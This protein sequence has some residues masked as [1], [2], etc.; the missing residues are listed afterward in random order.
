M[1]NLTTRKIVLGM[2]MVLMLAFSVQGTADAINAL[3]PTFSPTD[4]NIVEIN[5]TITLT[6]IS[7]TETLETVRESVT[8]SVRGSG[9][10]TGATQTNFLNPDGN[11]D[12][13][14]TWSE[15]GVNSD[16]SVGP[17][18][19]SVTIT[20][21]SA[22]EVTVTVTY[23]ETYDTN[24]SRNTSIVGTFYVPKQAYQVG[25]ND[26]VRLLGVTKGVGAGY[27]A[28][29]NFRIHTGDGRNN[30]VTYAIA[31]G[32]TLYIREGNRYRN[33][34]AYIKSNETNG[35]LTTSS[36]ADVWLEMASASQT[37]T[38]TVVTT[39]NETEGVYILRVPKLSVTA[40]TLEDDGT[41][42][43]A[44]DPPNNPMTAQPV[45]LMGD[46]E[47]VI[48]ADAI[49]VKVKQ[50]SVVNNQ[51]VFTTDVANVPVKFDVVDKSVTGGYLI[52]DA[53]ATIVDANNNLIA[54]ADRPRAARTLYVRTDD[55]NIAPVGFQFGTAE[56]TSEI[57]VSVT[58]NRINISKTIDVVIGD[59][60]SSQ[61]S[62]SSNTRDS[63]NSNVF[64]LVA[65]VADK[66]GNPLWGVPV[67]FR[68]RFG[69]LENTPTGET[70]TLPDDSPIA[71]TTAE[72]GRRVTDYTTRSGLAR[73]IYDL[74]SNTGSQEIHASI[75]DTASNR[76][77]VTF[78]VNG[79]ADTST[80][81]G[82]DTG[83]TANTITISPAT[84][85]G[86]PG[87]TV[88]ITISNPAGAP[89][90]LSSPSTTDFPQT[91]FAPASGIATSFTSTVTLPDR[92]DTY[93]I[94]AATTT[95][96]VTAG[97]AT[98]T[99]ATAAK[100][101]LA[102]SGETSG[103]PGAQITVA[104]IATDATGAREVG[105]DF[106]ISA[107]SI[108]TARGTTGANGVGR[109]IVT[110]PSTVSTYSLTAK[111]DGYTDRP[112]S[113]TVSTTGQ[114]TQ[115]QPTPPPTPPS[116]VSEPSRIV[117]NGPA[118]RSGTVNEALEAPLLAQ[119]LDADDDG[120]ENAIVKFSVKQGRARLSQRGDGKA[121]N[122]RTDSQGYARANLTPL[123]AG[124]ITIDA[125][126]RG[127]R[128]TVSFTITT[129][130]APASG[131]PDA[132]D[133]TPSTTVS[134]VLNAGVSA[135]S[136]PPM[137]WV[138]GGKIYALVDSEVKVFISNVENATNLTVGGG[139]V[140]WTAK[141][142]ETHGTLNSANLDGTDA[143]Q[144]RTVWGV[145]RGITLDPTGS[146]LYWVDA[147]GRLQRSELDGS[148]IENVIRNLSDPKD[149]AISDRNAYW[150]GNGSGTDTLSFISLSDPKKEINPIAATSGVYGGLAITNGKLYWTE[151]TSDAHGTLHSANLDGTQVKE[152][153]DEAIWGAPIGIAVDTARSRL[154]WTDAVG[155]LQRSNLDASGIHNV[156]KGLGMPADLV[157][158]NSIAEPTGT[159]PKKTTPTASNLKYDVNGDGAVD[160]LDVGLVAGA[161]NTTQ[162]KY[163]VNDDGVVNV[164]DLLAV[165]DNRDADAAAA[166]T[167]L[168]MKLTAA[169]VDGIQAQI[170]L[171]IAMGDRS[172]TAL[173]TLI[174]LQQLIATARPEKTQLL[175]NYPNPFN[176]ETWIP[177][178]LATD[179]DV[180]ITIYNAQGV[181]IR[182]L[183]L[184]QQSAGYYTDR[185]RAAYWDGR[186]ALGE[187]VASGIYFYQLETDAM[188]SMRKM[189]ILK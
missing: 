172:P 189:V 18:T 92:Q 154:Y 37:V 23:T 158:S 119:V 15:S 188:S 84:I 100:G 171:L 36:S 134:P 168:G 65:R 73:V 187:Q 165:T 115:Q 103:T 61:L 40:A 80:D 127:V 174:Y 177:Y 54:A 8:V 151:Q 90:F 53:D 175:A 22:G 5:G 4:L 164:L 99:V 142:T 72:D 159:T 87:D 141:T 42:T 86:E 173:K 2:L 132:G 47:E 45:R 29:D 150:I 67:I 46:P 130:L 121:I 88:T 62:I 167:R 78:V 83:T 113:V 147:A 180:K 69:D 98:V 12:T 35:T 91:N 149:L 85:T 131:T 183:P 43:T 184:G 136:R 60:A 25:L 63:G 107:P 30:R 125:E 176:P 143:K 140:Y 20:V 3:S 19:D 94:F 55:S 133:P 76:Q 102:I 118:T 135:A 27:G 10:G 44:T 16:G 120:F 169:Q 123:S 95:A 181:V 153:R 126:A 96:G 58:G 105:V 38:A 161:L 1:K 70:F 139:K 21:R 56:G 148:G 124:K 106:T 170:E 114:P 50:S 144:L 48:S 178:E 71:D 34:N 112:F 101:T 89:V 77:E 166:P 110:L 93:T 104:V 28:T 82:T 52:P 75:D 33:D 157:I 9:V 11:R 160:N 31:G 111:A 128:Q 64:H 179:T 122:V 24:R 145:P 79:P 117:V 109:A 17:T 155:R 116:T 13:S 26:T 49:K 81:T 152:L 7:G 162:A 129:G 108:T 156:A 138:S 32:G 41:H 39:S 97:S 186:N 185:E 51:V 74:G 66:D 182:T 146:K 6:N 57:T 163:D 14:H 59:E 68:T 137:L